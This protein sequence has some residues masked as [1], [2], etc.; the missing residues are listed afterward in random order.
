[1]SFFFLA[2]PVYIF[3]CKC[4]I[5]NTIATQKYYFW[6]YLQCLNMDCLSIQK[7]N[8]HTYFTDLHNMCL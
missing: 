2:H 1:M 7:H 3:C 5:L 6:V 4:G 8:N